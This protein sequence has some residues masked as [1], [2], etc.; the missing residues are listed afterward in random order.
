MNVSLTPEL[1]QLVN[2]EIKS[3][4]YKSANE[5]VREGLRLVRLRRQKLAALRR[6]IQ[7]GIDEIERGEYVEYTSVEELFEDIEAAVVK[8]AAKK[9]KPR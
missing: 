3:G 6:E 4:S 2:D 8:R 7:I 9:P 1:E 5:V